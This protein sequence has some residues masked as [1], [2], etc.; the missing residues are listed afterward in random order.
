MTRS[1][2][3]IS[4]FVTPCLSVFC[5]FFCFLPYQTLSLSLSLSLCTTTSWFAF[6]PNAVRWL[7][8]SSFPLLW[9][10]AC[11]LHVCVC[12]LYECVCVC[13]CSC[14]CTCACVSR[15][16]E[17]YYC[18]HIIWWGEWFRLLAGC[19]AFI[20]N[21]AANIWTVSTLTDSVCV[22]VCVYW[23][24]C[25]G[26]RA[27]SHWMGNRFAQINQRCSINKR[28]PIPSCLQAA[29]LRAWESSLASSR[30]SCS[31]TQASCRNAGT[32]TQPGMSFQPK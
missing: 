15:V 9:E 26:P 24:P 27:V 13:L 6:A 4:L 17:Q 28:S 32:C 21:R 25:L 19:P 5:F 11:T 22:C 31:H 10:C 14:M 2:L 16:S 20:W 23:G 29:I 1:S 30:T 7:S 18:K 8:I 12:A 3:L